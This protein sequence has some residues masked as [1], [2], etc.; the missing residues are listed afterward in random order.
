M[1]EGLH[2]KSKDDEGKL[3]CVEFCCIFCVLHFVRVC[4]FLVEEGLGF[5]GLKQ[6]VDILLCFHYRLG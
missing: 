4:S 3:L 1:E 5:E 2:E 6:C